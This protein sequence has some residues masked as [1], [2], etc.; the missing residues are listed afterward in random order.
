MRIAAYITSL[1]ETFPHTIKSELDY[2]A[3]TG[4]WQST[5]TGE[6]GTGGQTQPVSHTWRSEWRMTSQSP[7]MEGFFGRVEDERCVTWSEEDSR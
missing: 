5:S 1:Q 7:T 6:T 2:W 3:A 4:G